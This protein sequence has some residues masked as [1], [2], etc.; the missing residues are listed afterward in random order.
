[1]KSLAPI[2]LSLSKITDVAQLAE[3]K[4]YLTDRIKIVSE[5]QHKAAC[6]ER[7]AQL[8][9]LKNGDPLYAHW[10]GYGGKGIY[11]GESLSF[12]IA[13]PH[14]KLLWVRRTRDNRLIHLTPSNLVIYDIRPQQCADPL[15]DAAKAL[16]IKADAVFA[17]AIAQR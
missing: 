8:A 13:Q 14:K 1:M 17:E 12:Y 6:A 3:L 7:W 16:H 4:R 5:R 2:K 11:H 9:K 15:S 10:R